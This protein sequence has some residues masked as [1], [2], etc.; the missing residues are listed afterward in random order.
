M[1]TYLGSTSVD[2][3]Y[4]S[5]TVVAIGNFDGVHLGH[6]EILA[7][8]FEH[9][10]KLNIPVSVL[11]FNPHPTM[12]LRPQAPLKLLMTYDEKRNQLA[13][14]GVD[15]CVE[16]K[17]DQEFAATTAQDFFFEILKKRLHAK[18]IVVGS[19]FA[20]GRKREGSTQLLKEYCSQTQTELELVSPVL[21]DGEP[22]SSSRVR[23][24]L[25]RGEVGAAQRLLGSPFFYRGEVIHGDHRG[26]TIGFPT[27]NMR[28]EEK[29]PLLPGVYATTVSW[30]GKVYPSVT[31]IGKSPTFHSGENMNL[32]PLRI[33]THLLHQNF[34]LYHEILELRFFEHIRAE[35][36]FESITEL[37][38]QI[39]R[40]AN[41]AEQLLQSRDI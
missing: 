9:S 20:F 23:D 2:A 5:D 22:V 39:Q 24:Y 29:F 16:E 40:D 36:K 26:R 38:A 41:L 18:A 32:I 11:T 35:K 13:K 15:F 17:F 1:K 10:R 37:T 3:D 14:L 28:C 27:A 4:P 21:L 31:N 33:E 34:D 30:Q 6:Q 25:S 7:K 12:E 8:A 19:D